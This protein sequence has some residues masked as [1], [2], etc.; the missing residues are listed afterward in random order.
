MLA[1][2]TLEFQDNLLSGFRLNENQYSSFHMP[3]HAAYLLS[4]NLFDLS[5]VAGRFAVIAAPTLSK[6][7][8]FPSLIL[9]DLVRPGE[10]VDERKHN[11]EIG[12]RTCVF[13]N[14]YLDN[15]G[16]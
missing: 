10:G 15:L 2:C 3:Q 16:K 8:L 9:G 11:Y 4:K 5:T 13:H 14:F 1:N 7:R 6:S 12:E